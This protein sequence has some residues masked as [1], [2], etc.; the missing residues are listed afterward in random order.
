M[1]DEQINKLV[2]YLEL[3]RTEWDEWFVHPS[4]TLS[5]EMV[6][7]YT[8]RIETVLA[9]C[10]ILGCRDEINKRLVWAATYK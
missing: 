8:N 7:Y 6:D 3:L 2:T 5:C 4:E 9:V 1:S 10:T